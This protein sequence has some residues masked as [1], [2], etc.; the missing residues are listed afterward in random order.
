M[1]AVKAYR[2]NRGIAK[3]FLT[4]PLDGGEWSISRPGRFVP[5][6]SPLNS[7]GKGLVGLQNLSEHFGEKHLLPLNE[8][9]SRF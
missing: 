8:N 4:S 5:E 1:H 2:R 6:K 9:I 3:W 7:M